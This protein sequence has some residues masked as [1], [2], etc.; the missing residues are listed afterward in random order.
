MYLRKGSWRIKIML[1]ERRTSRVGC[2]WKAGK[3]L[4]VRSQAAEG[5]EA[6]IR[7]KR[8]RLDS[9]ALEKKSELQ[10][11]E[12]I[13]HLT[14]GKIKNATNRRMAVT[15]A[16]LRTEELGVVKIRSANRPSCL[17][18]RNP[19][20]QLQY[21]VLSTYV[22]PVRCLVEIELCVEK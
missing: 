16:M 21:T 14:V 10:R 15:L 13:Q 19:C 1:R 2:I 9:P 4:G 8:K 5:V 6:T 22:F 11:N 7:L 12:D 17:N 3:H 18:K 20:N